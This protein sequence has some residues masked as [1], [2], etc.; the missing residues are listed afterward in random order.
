MSSWTAASSDC[1][2]PVNNYVHV[3]TADLYRPNA[4]LTPERQ[5][6][7]V[8]T[9]F[10]KLGHSPGTAELWPHNF[11]HRTNKFENNR[12]YH[13]HY[14][15]LTSLVAAAAEMTIGTSC[16][17][18]CHLT[19]RYPDLYDYGNRDGSGSHLGSGKSDGIGP[20][21]VMGSGNHVGGGTTP[22]P[23]CAYL[24]KLSNFPDNEVVL[25]NINASHELRAD[26]YSTIFRYVLSP[27]ESFFVENHSPVG[28][29]AGMAT[30]RR[31]TP[32]G[33]VTLNISGLAIVH[34]DT[35][36]SNEWQQNTPLHHYQ[37]YLLQADGRI[38]LENPRGADTGDL[39]SDVQ[40][41][42]ASFDTIPSTR[43]WDRAD[44]QF[45]IR[46][47]SRPGV[48]MTFVSGADPV[49]DGA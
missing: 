26:D 48:V 42:A 44:S 4:R 39:Y 49:E 34:C 20:Y 8:L 28:L 37:T 21:C 2:R 6:Y 9:P 43:R 38:D 16:H 33:I 15:M 27:N 13:T 32:G 46:D 24:R 10:G 40:G 29:R 17:E 18:L 5:G 36:G 22:V 41:V 31:R 47:I 7:Q 25:N 12:W 3:K 14:Y 35:E 45:V 1:S 23:P 11:T 30:Y 19:L